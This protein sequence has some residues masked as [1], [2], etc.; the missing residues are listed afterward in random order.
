MVDDRLFCTDQ[1]AIRKR[2]SP[3][4]CFSEWSGV[5]FEQL[6]ELY[7]ATAG[8]P[9]V[10]HALHGVPTLEGGTYTV[11]LVPVGLQ[12]GDLLCVTEDETRHMVHGVL[13]GLAAIHQAGFVHRDLRWDNLARCHS[14]RRWFLI[15]L[16]S[17]APADE[18]PVA[19]FEPAG[20][21]PDTTLVGGRYTFASDLYQLGRVVLD[22]CGPLVSSAEGRAFMEAILTRPAAQQRSAADLL[23]LEWLR[24][25]GPSCGAA[26]AQPHER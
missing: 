12:S 19:G 10:V 3:W 18:E 1:P 15:D 20:W 11:D 4:S 21:L 16:E 22:K 23:S 5:R 2:L 9:G 8:R 6:R 13:H 24:C 17:C 26:G 7:R 14:G 25:Q